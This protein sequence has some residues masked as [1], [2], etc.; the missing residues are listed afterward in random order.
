MKRPESLRIRDLTIVVARGRVPVVR[1]LSI[2]IESGTSYGLVGESGSGKSL[3]C[4]AILGLLPPGV[5]ASGAV[6][7]GTRSLLDLSSGEMHLVRGSEI[8][9]VS[10]DPMAALNPVLRVGQAIAQVIRSHEKVDRRAA[11]ARA[12]ALM[13]TVGIR[14]AERRARSYPHEFSGGMR[15]RIVIAMALAARPTLLLADEP[16]TALDV[17]V[18][19]GVLRLLYELRGENAMSLLL[20]SH[21]LSVVAGVCE[22]VG[23]MYA[24]QLVEEGPTSEV[25]QHPRHPYTK[26]LV[27]S[28]PEAPGSGRLRAIAG[29]PPEPGNLP[30]GCSFSPRC[31]L[32]TDECKVR[33]IGVHRVTEDHWA[34]CVYADRLGVGR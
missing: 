4:R 23:V 3:T 20:V 19:A 15:Q 17:I 2:E 5:K 32:A 8:G 18:Q 24:G 25:L 22:R 31:A 12:V 9:M 16:T 6:L 21:D 29:S 26:A 1:E 34:R 27:D 13:S 30:V 28:H 11:H 14:D 7:F 33:P 10:Q